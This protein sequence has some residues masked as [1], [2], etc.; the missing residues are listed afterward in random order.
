MNG[1]MWF[2]LA[3]QPELLPA[4]PASQSIGR[5]GASRNAGTGF[6]TLLENLVHSQMPAEEASQDA[7]FV[8]IGRLNEIIEQL[9]TEEEWTEEEWNLLADLITLIVQVDE[10]IVAQHPSHEELMEWRVQ[11]APKMQQIAELVL[12]QDSFPEL[13]RFAPLFDMKRM[14]NGESEAF[15]ADERVLAEGLKANGREMA[16]FVENNA[17]SR[18]LTVEMAQLIRHLATDT[19]DMPNAQSDGQLRD[20]AGDQRGASVP[21][22]SLV[23]PEGAMK[24]NG[25]AKSA[26][27]LPT[28]AQAVMETAASQSASL[29]TLSADVKYQEIEQ[30]FQYRVPSVTM[31]Q[32]EAEGTEV[33]VRMTNVQTLTGYHVTPYAHNPVRSDAL[34]LENSEVRTGYMTVRIENWAEEMSR[35]LMRMDTFRGEGMSAVKIKLVPDHL[36]QLDVHLKMQN[37]QLT[38]QFI[39]DR[40]SGKELIE[41][42]VSLLRIALQN[43]G[44]QVEKIEVTHQPAEQHGLLQ[45]Q[46]NQQSFA[47]S[48]QN[49]PQ[50]EEPKWIVDDWSEEAEE[51]EHPVRRLAHGGVFDATA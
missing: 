1:Q 32:T 35:M 44:I 8:P 42:Q 25:E 51:S 47:D 31:G 23:M 12:K 11:N 43:Q 46:R 2:G 34:P 20:V 9:L 27:P 41:S 17:N 21:F 36:G 24:W 39:A 22:R 5:Q 40:L 10:A 18:K 38:A 19:S 50:S 3:V 15:K 37:G 26:T 4:Q 6:F 45:D 49:K 48:Q 33:P 13:E 7:S 30:A 16:L 14:S 29:T 28:A